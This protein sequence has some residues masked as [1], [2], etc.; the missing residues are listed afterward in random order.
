MVLNAEIGEK[1]G[2][3]LGAIMFNFLQVGVKTQ[4]LIGTLVQVVGM[5]A[6]IFVE[7]Y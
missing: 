1:V 5:T 6:A 3:I 4:L 7:E 2:Y